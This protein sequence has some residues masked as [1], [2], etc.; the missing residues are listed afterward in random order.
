MPSRFDLTGGFRSHFD[1]DDEQRWAENS[2]YA[3]RHDGL[4]ESRL[5]RFTREA[6]EEMELES[7]QENII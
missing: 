5:E 4:Y 6:Q 3:R 2:L 7:E 1:F